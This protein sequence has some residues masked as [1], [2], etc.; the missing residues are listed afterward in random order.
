[1]LNRGRAYSLL[2]GLT[3]VLCPVFVPAQDLGSELDRYGDTD[4]EMNL[5]LA[6]V[7][8]A[9]LGAASPWRASL[10]M[11]RKSRRSDDVLVFYK[12]LN[13]TLNSFRSPQSTLGRGGARNVSCEM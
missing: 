12:I 1:M 6:G 10:P 7:A 5:G 11:K 4:E 13:L 8:S 2:S 3:C 9:G